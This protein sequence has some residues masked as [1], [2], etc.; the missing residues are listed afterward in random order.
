M[1]SAF[2]SDLQAT[3]QG[4]TLKVIATTQMTTAKV[5]VIS[6]L[7]LQHQQL[8]RRMVGR[9]RDFE[10]GNVKLIS[11]V[12]LHLTYCQAPI[13]REILL[14]SL[15]DSIVEVTQSP[16]MFLLMVIAGRA[17][18]QRGK[19]KDHSFVWHKV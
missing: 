11:F 3:K 19:G 2:F 6:D 7:V 13:R 5:L 9:S 16:P 4:Q 17:Q 1:R 10:A 14:K 18:A 12:S 8:A 15:D